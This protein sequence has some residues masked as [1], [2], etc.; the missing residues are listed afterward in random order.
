MKTET[1]PEHLGDFFLSSE[2]GHKPVVT[3]QGLDKTF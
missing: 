2:L 1:V 3:D